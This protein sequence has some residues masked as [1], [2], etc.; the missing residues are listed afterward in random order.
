MAKYRLTWTGDGS[1]DLSQVLD[2][3]GVP[4]VLTKP[5]AEA[6]VTEGGYRHPLVQ[7]CLKSGLKATP[8]DGPVTQAAAPPAP[9]APAVPKTAPEPAPVKEPTPKKVEMKD[10][11]TSAS[12]LSIKSAAATVEPD[13]EPVE[14]ST[15]TTDDDDE[16]DSSPSKPKRGRRGR[17]K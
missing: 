4:I 13:A 1:L 5:G 2:D 17:S 14:E 7:R 9:K 16:T 11:F 6:V 8:L 15:A 3:R 10:A 12:D